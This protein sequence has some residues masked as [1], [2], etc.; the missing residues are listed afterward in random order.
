MISP[1]NL[2][3]SEMLIIPD[4]LETNEVHQRT[5]TKKIPKTDRQIS[6][7]YGNRCVYVYDMFIVYMSDLNMYTYIYI[8]VCMYIYIYLLWLV[9]EV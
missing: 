1:I 7:L 3:S 5:P 4:R 6:T 8:Y 9:T 2:P